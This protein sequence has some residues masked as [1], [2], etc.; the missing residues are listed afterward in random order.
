PASDGV[1][2][3][4]Q[5]VG[6]LTKFGRNCGRRATR[7][8]A[9]REVAAGQPLLRGIAAGQPLLRGI[10]ARQPLLPEAVRATALPQKKEGQTRKRSLSF[11]RVWRSGRDSNP[12]PPA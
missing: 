1:M 2:N 11:M 6:S 10:A 3:L 4:L 12:R 8:V 9:A 5:H 7:R